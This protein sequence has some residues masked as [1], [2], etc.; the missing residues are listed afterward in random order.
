MIMRVSTNHHEM[1]FA[2]VVRFLQLAINSILDATPF[3]DEFIELLVV[4][5]LILYENTYSKEDFFFHSLAWHC[6]VT[7][8]YNEIWMAYINKIVSLLE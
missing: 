6:Q 7:K 8:R 4:E 5:T 3:G 2:V 1:V